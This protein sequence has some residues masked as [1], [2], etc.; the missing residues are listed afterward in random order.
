MFIEIAFGEA[1]WRIKSQLL[2]YKLIGKTIKLSL[3]AATL[4]G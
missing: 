3:N 2:R 4:K 1:I